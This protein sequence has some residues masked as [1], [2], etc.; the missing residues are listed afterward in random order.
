VNAPSNNFDEATREMAKWQQAIDLARSLPDNL[1]GVTLVTG[2]VFGVT[3]YIPADH[4][5]YEAL[6]RELGPDFEQVGSWRPRP[7]DGVIDVELVH[8]PTGMHVG[9]YMSTRY[10]GATCRRVQVG[11]ETRPVYEIQCGTAAA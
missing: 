4:A 7:D 1:S 10:E 6:R 8:K 2:N 11:E 3:I 9:V 5:L